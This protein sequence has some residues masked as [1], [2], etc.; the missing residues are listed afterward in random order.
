MSAQ[1]S[2]PGAARETG[3]DVSEGLVSSLKLREAPYVPLEH[4]ARQSALVHLRRVRFLAYL[5]LPFALYLLPVLMGYSWNALGEGHNILNP[6]EGYVGRLPDRRITV[7][8]WG[9]SVVDVPFHA[10]LQA[11]LR[12]AELPLWNPYQGLGEPF[13][14]QGEESPYS[15]F[16]I[17][18][19]L[20]PYALSNYVTFG[21]FYLSAVCLYLFL[22]GVGLSDAAAIFGGI[23]FVVSG[24]LS[25][26]IGRPNIADQV[27]LIPVLFWAAERAMR[28][29][30]AHA[31]VILALVAA[32]HATGGF[33]QIAMLSALVTAAFCLLYTHYLAVSRR[34]WLQDAA[35]VLGAFALGNGLMAF[36]LFPL[37]EA[38]GTTFNKNL[39]FLSLL[40]PIGFG[41]VVAFFFPLLLGYA[42][43]QGWSPPP[44]V[45][46]WDN[47]YAFS[48]T[49][50]LLIAV[51]GLA[52]R[53]WPSSL[54]R[55]LY[56]FFLLTTVFLMLRYVGT[57]PARLVDYLPIIG[58]QSP[59]HATGIMVF[60]LVVA[61]AC[62]L[63][64]VKGWNYRR[65]VWLAVAM[66][67]YFVSTLG[68][69]IEQSGFTSSGVVSI[70]TPVATGSLLVT[71][72]LSVL[73]IAALWL[74]GRWRDKPANALI[75]FL[76]A[77][78]VAELAVYIPLGNGAFEFLE[79]RLALSTLIVVGGVFLALGSRRAATGL[80]ATVLVGV[81]VLIELPGP[82]LPRQFNVDTP[83]RFLN[84]LEG[85]EG[86][87]Y[88]SFGIPP[89]H[90]SIGGVQDISVVGPLAPR[91]FASFVQL[92]SDKKT[93]DDYQATTH[94]MLAGPWSFSLEQYQH[95]KPIFDWAGIRYL[96]LD[97]A[98]FNPGARTDDQAL[99]RANTG[100][101]VAYSDDRVRVLESPQALPKAEFW[102]RVE[103]YPTQAAILA[104]YKQ[105]PDAIL[106]PPRVETLNAPRSLASLSA[107]PAGPLDAQVVDYEPNRVQLRVDAPSAGLL[108]LKDS[109]FPGWQ[110]VVNGQTAD[111]VRVNG[112]VRGVVV[113]APG[114][115]EVQMV[116]RPEG[117]GRGLWLSGAIALLLLATAG[118]ALI[119]R[120]PGLPLW[121]IVVGLLLTGAMLDQT[122]QAYFGRSI[123]S[124]AAS[125]VV[126]DAPVDIGDT[127]GLTAFFV[128]RDQARPGAS[129]P[130]DAAQATSLNVDDLA[131]NGTS[132]ELLR[133]TATGSPIRLRGQEGQRIRL[134]NVGK[135]DT[136]AQRFEGL[137]AV[138][139]NGKWLMDTASVQPDNPNSRFND[140]G[141]G[142]T[143]PGFWVSPADAGY[144]ITR[145]HDTDGN[146]IHIG[147]HSNGE[148]RLTLYDVVSGQDPASSYIA[149]ASPSENAST[150]LRVRADRVQRPDPQDNYSLG[151]YNVQAGDWFEVSELA[152]LVGTLP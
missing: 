113:P 99:L 83:P 135:W 4:P 109:Y 95:V 74:V 64:A 31:F 81:A 2:D 90:S 57:A 52:M 68:P 119:G 71:A 39:P 112:L 66:C 105:H 34:Q 114:H 61:A 13:A 97:N 41:N 32:L 127:S 136:A 101:R 78:T 72:Y 54:Q 103:M 102:G 91:E 87:A 92:I 17:A 115:Y 21:V 62:A 147:A 58:R 122:A 49:A 70:N 18:R 140:L 110:A 131:L 47:L 3:S 138:Y 93:A 19:A 89:D 123:A 56:W 27:A 55:R 20:V 150:T 33:I 77:V 134:V 148:M 37:L 133:L 48:G 120:R 85:A 26:H 111:V 88:R 23:G 82:G 63:D 124:K 149:R 75:T 9:A 35:I 145:G 76:T 98:Y 69:L 144:R 139:R 14:A 104:D 117:F 100:V 106:G 59:K 7:E 152:L 46:D 130:N 60:C 11:Y 5:A 80:F 53:R 94:F 121:A 50:L 128:P 137:D 84:W 28:R 51:C 45:A 38:M 8:A 125:L 146:F 16:S 6:P 30:T 141:E 42:F 67:L 15:P 29:R 79:L 24:A 36:Y 143:I 116:Y 126:G 65:A 12:S 10:R 151:L 22:R 132:G 43:F 86:E 118:F 44:A 107:G 1:A 96:V 108:V 142:D 25:L 40:T 129:V 73:I